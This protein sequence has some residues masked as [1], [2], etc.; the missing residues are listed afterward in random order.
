MIE[1]RGAHFAARTLYR[2]LRILSQIITISGR[3]LRVA[4]SESP[5][6]YF[7]ALIAT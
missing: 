1:V 5:V 2:T 3:T 4:R 6:R 7:T